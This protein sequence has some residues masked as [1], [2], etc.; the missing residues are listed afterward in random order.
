MMHGLANSKF[1]KSLFI[2]YANP[3]SA[4]SVHISGR[5]STFWNFCSRCSYSMFQIGEGHRHW[6]NIIVIFRRASQGKVKGVR[7]GD[8]EGQEMDPPPPNHGLGNCLFR[9]VVSRLW[10]CGGSVSCFASACNFKQLEG[11]NTNTIWRKKAIIANGW[12]EVNITLMWAEQQVEHSLSSWSV[13]HFLSCFDS[14]VNWRSLY[15]SV[16]TDFINAHLI[17]KHPVYNHRIFVLPV[18]AYFHFLFWG[19][20]CERDLRRCVSECAIGSCQK[21]C[22]VFSICPDTYCFFFI[23]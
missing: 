2:P 15:L 10:M 6:W 19:V 3:E 8:R 22:A 1:K 4:S 14:G 7:S 13:Q 18:C 9:N 5:H 17:S 11:W 20:F 21:H 12:C 23:L 16:L